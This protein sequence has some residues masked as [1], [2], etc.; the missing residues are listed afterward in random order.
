MVTGEGEWCKEGG[1]RG[2]EF[3]ISHI[4]SFINLGNLSSCSTV[5]CTG[6]DTAQIEKA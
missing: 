2:R 5:L 6:S 1:E 4:C 3:N